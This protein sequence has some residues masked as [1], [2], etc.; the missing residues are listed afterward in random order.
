MPGTNTSRR[1]S[2]NTSTMLYDRLQRLREQIKDTQH[3]IEIVQ[4]TINVARED[5]KKYLR[6][7]HGNQWSKSIKKQ[8]AA[9]TEKNTL[10]EKIEV[11]KKDM[12]SVKKSL[13]KKGG[14]DKRKT[15]KQFKKGM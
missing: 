14:S 11:L 6:D 13:I 7:Y 4:K 10:M 5:Q 1:R 2:S 15:A 3:N 12:I 8:M 9:N